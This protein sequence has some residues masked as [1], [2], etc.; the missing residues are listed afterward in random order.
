MGLGRGAL[1]RNIFNFTIRD[2]MKK[3]TKPKPKAAKPAKKS[4]Y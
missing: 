3:A 2:T 4:K 1:E